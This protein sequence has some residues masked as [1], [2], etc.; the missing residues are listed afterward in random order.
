ML[1]NSKG[2]LDYVLRSGIP[3]DRTDIAEFLKIVETS[4]FQQNRNIARFIE[5]LCFGNMRLALSMFSTFMTSGA[6][7]VDKMLNIYRRSGSYYVAFHEFVKSIMLSE[8][9][10][11]KDSASPILNLFDCGAERHSGH[12]S[13]LRIMRVLQLRRGESTNEGQGYVDIGQ[14]VAMSEDVFDDRENLVRALNR[15]VVRQLVE[16]NTR[17]TDS[18]MGASHV[19]IT[20]SGWYY[21]RY[22]VSSFSY[23]DLVLQDT[24][25]N[26]SDTEKVLRSFVQ[27]VD[28]LSDREEEKLAR[29]EVRFARVRAFLEYLRSEEEHEATLYDLRISGG[30]WATPFMPVIISQIEREIEWIARRLKENR[31]LFPEDIKVWSDESEL[32]VPSGEHDEDEVEDG[33][34]E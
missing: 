22:L 1:E 16:V 6:T 24:P 18:I 4:I 30:V 8:R 11:Y 31:E 27:Q 14:L 33:A 34:A 3:I 21:C 10:Y 19:R 2:P 9:R 13:S 15:L 23:I 5:A 28:N 32:E 29:L 12:F 20:S 26:D 7:D 17:S 25:L